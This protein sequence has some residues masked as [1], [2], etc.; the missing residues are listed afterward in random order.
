MLLNK[1]RALAIMKEEKLDALVATTPESVCYMTGHAG[2]M[3]WTYRGITMERGCQGY[4]ILTPDGARTLI[5]HLLIDLPY[6][7]NN[8]VKVDDLWVYGPSFVKKPEGYVP[9]IPEEKLL[10]EMMDSAT[11]RCVDSATALVGALKA[12]GV[13]KGRVGIEFFGLSPTVEAVLR[14]EFKGIEFVEAGE[15]LRKIRWIKTP[16]EIHRLRTAAYVNEK[17]LQEVMKAIK[18]GVTELEMRKVFK[19]SLGSQDATQD[20]FTC[21]GGLRA[22]LFAGISDYRFKPGDMVAIDPGCELNK[23]HADTGLCAVLGEPT[24]EMKDLWKKQIDVWEAGLAILGPGLTPAKLFDTMSAV[25]KKHFGMVGGY[26]GHCIGIE[27]REMPIINRVP[28]VGTKLMDMEGAPPFQPGMVVELEIPFTIF[29][30]YVVHIEDCF[31]ITEKGYEPLIN[32]KRDLFVL[33]V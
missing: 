27:P 25:Q 23:Y 6:V 22:G 18:P 28:G 24:K 26:Y 1:E 9:Q 8:N 17:A 4:S 21:S 10:A 14:R 30:G 16:D 3:A 33:G 19:G 7:I 11:R 12:R 20:F 15:I 2:W 5:T 32:V 29:G 31:I 13:T